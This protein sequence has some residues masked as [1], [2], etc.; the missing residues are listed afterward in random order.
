MICLKYRS[1][2][3]SPTQKSLVILTYPQC[4]YTVK[5]INIYFD[6]LSCNYQFLTTFPCFFFQQTASCI[7][8][9]CHTNHLFPQTHIIVHLLECYNGDIT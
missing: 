2:P 1:I 7:L 6:L 9:S 8:C 4:L 5:H 3:Y